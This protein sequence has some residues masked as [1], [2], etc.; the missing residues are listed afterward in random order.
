MVSAPQQS[1]ARLRLASRAGGSPR[2]VEASG[3][4]M[5]SPG[6]HLGRGDG[7]LPLRARGGLPARHH[8]A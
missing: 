8:G 4:G 5:A 7:Q 2:L 1:L 3:P 6:G